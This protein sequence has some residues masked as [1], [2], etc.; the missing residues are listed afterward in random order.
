MSRVHVFRPLTLPDTRLYG[1]NPDDQSGAD[2]EQRS[3]KQN[4]RK[5]KPLVCFDAYT[6][7]AIIAG[8]TFSSV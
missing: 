6:P 8:S 2:C 3:D 4:A 1:V 7:F 5:D